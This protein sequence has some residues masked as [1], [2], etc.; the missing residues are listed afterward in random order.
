MEKVIGF[1]GYECEDIAIYLG[2]VLQ[3]LG[4]K[5][6][7]V[8]RTEQELLCEMLNIRTERGKTWKEGEYCGCRITNK[9][10]NQKEYDL[11]F[12]LFGYRLNHPKL[13]ECG[14]LIMITDGVPAHAA[15]LH[16]TGP[17]ECKSFLV[18]RNLIAMKHSE[19]YLAAL[20]GKDNEFKDLPYD[21]RDIRSRC[22]LG[23]YTRCEI[24]RLSPGMKRILISLVEM[25]APEYQEEFVR[26]QMK[27]I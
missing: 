18:I 22:S 3:T 27:K 17:W 24:K 20:A 25:A 13:Y 26:K 8:D 12:Y 7:I 19:E 10:V 9:G 11:I 15:L 23:A 5:V 21:E 16:N 6:V 2:R 4:K 1:I 14:K